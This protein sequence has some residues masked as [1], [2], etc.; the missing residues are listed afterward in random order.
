MRFLGGLWLHIIVS[1]ILQISVPKYYSVSILGKHALVLKWKVL[2]DG[3]HFVPE[4]AKFKTEKILKGTKR[5]V[6]SGTPRRLSV[7]LLLH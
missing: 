2:M 3:A 7:M 5:L 1:C 4:R 6:E